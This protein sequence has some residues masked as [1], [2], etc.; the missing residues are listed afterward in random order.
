MEERF[1]LAHKIASEEPAPQG[2]DTDEEEDKEAD[3]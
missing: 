3:T 2:L 1:Q